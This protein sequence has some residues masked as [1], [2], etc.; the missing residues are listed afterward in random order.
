MKKIY[1]E[2]VERKMAWDRRMFCPKCGGHEYEVVEQISPP[3]ENC[4]R[5]QCPQC[6][7]ETEMA[8]MEQLA[9]T[10]WKWPCQMDQ[11]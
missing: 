5:I 6:G 3:E 1:E 7:Y 9:R 10:R 8:P 2:V 11:Y 4:W